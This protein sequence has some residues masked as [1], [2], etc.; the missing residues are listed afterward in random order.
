[1]QTAI[2]TRIK[3]YYEDITQSRIDELHTN[4]EQLQFKYLH[5]FIIIITIYLSAACMDVFIINTIF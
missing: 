5:C 3:A 2:A 1:V 4:R